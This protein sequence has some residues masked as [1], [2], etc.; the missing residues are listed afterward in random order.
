MVKSFSSLVKEELSQ[1]NNLNKKDLV[2][3]ELMGYLSTAENLNISSYSTQNAHNINRFSKLLTNIGENDFS[4]SLKGKTYTIK[5]KKNIN[6]KCEIKTEEQLRSFVRGAFLGSGTITNPKNNYHLEILFTNETNQS[7][8]ANILNE[9]NISAKTLV[10]GNKYIVYV[11]EGE[12][13]SKML[14]FMGANKA[15]LEFEE[16]RVLKD[17]KNNV[18]RRVNCETANMTKIASSATKQ[19]EDIKFLKSKH[20][21]NSLSDKDKEIANLRLKNPEASIA[22]IS[23]M[24]NPKITKSGA[25]HRMSMI[26]KRA[27]ELRLNKK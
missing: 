5:T 11:E 8:M 4:I 25:Y 9:N 7:K 18:N 10:R 1:I 13:I 6:S 3:S 27:D 12:S 16:L 17:V 19:I 15:V 14:A 23:E 21:F 22:E 2:V 26:Q 20:V 24:T